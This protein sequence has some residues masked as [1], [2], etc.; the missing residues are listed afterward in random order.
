MKIDENELSRNAMG[1]TELM[2]AGLQKHV[3]PLFSE[4]FLDQFQ[5][6]PSR[7]RNLDEKKIRIYWVHDLE[8]DP[9]TEHLANEGWNKFHAIVFVSYWQRDRYIAKYNIP[10]HLCHVIKNAVDFPVPVDH[11]RTVPGV[12]GPLKFIY[13]PTPHRGLELLIPVMKHYMTEHPETELHVYSSFDLYGWSEKNS[14]YQR[15]FDDIDEHP[16]MFNHGTVPNQEIQNRLLDAHVFVYPSIW[17]ETS[18]LCLIEAMV[19]GCHCIHSDFAVLPETAMGYTQMYGF[20]SD[21]QRHANAFYSNIID[22]PL[23]MKNYPIEVMSYINKHYSWEERK[24]EW[25]ELLGSLLVSYQDK[26]RRSFPARRSSE[27]TF[28]YKTG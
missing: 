16:K 1:G 6:I 12:D 4:D 8:T 5:I 10:Y 14:I 24:N 13:T 20:Q 9:E 26:Q 11:R 23:K 22:H 7:V 15:I 17:P 3:Y 18:C 28:T 27:T 2:L 21:P 19:A 25:Y